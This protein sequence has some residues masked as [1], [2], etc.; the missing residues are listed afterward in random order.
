MAEI[1]AAEELQT[2]V[3]ATTTAARAVFTD[4]QSMAATESPPG[5]FFVWR[6]GD[7]SNIPAQKAFSLGSMSATSR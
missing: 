2:A 7:L 1:D 5:Q 4:A 3:M 6:T